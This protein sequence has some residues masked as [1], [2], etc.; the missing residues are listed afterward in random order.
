M[1]RRIAPGAV[2][3]HAGKRWRVDRVLGA[4]SV[5]LR[6]EGDPQPAE[7]AYAASTAAGSIY[8]EFAKH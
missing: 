8:P 5:L 2:V 6:G 4:D 7:L 3:E 1:E